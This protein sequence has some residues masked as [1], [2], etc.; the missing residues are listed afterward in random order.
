MQKKTKSFHK[1]KIKIL[2]KTKIWFYF[3][4]FYY[5]IYIVGK[6]EQIKTGT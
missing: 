2:I 4:S 1:K 6:T 3:K 5:L